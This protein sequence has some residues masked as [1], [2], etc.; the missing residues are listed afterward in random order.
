MRLYM[1]VA[2]LLA[3]LAQPSWAA[4]YIWQDDAGIQHASDQPPAG[5]EDDEFGP[6]Y[7]II[8]VP[9]LTTVTLRLLPQTPIDIDKLD[10]VEDDEQPAANPAVIMYTT[11]WCSICKHAKTYMAQKKVPYVEKDIETSTAARRE[12]L[13]LGG[14]G[15]PLILLDDKLLAGFSRRR[16]DE[17]YRQ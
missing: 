6:E 3:A 15:V 7:K 13:E 17:F 11:S 2:L 4:I 12:F 9:E 1:T 5:A 16:F 14:D 10:V 8:E